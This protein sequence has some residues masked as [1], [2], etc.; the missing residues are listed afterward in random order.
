MSEQ[1][2]IKAIQDIY[3]AFGRGDVPYIIDQ[4]TED[5]TWRTHFDPVVPWGGDYSGKAKVPKFFDAIF[6]AV[7]VSA[8][9]PQ[10]W[11]AQGDTVVSLGRFG[12]K[13]R[14]L[15]KAFNTRWVFIWKL[16]G[17]KVTSYEQ[18]HETTIADAFR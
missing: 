16:R 1:A 6:S 7:E 5:V 2:N 13:S 14:N 8:F 18:F 15:G 11:V 17:G 9:E 12:G 3:A 10:E 4:L